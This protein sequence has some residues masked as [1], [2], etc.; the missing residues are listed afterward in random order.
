MAD[1]LVVPCPPLVADVVRLW[2]TLELATDAGTRAVVVLNR[3]RTRT[4]SLTEAREV[5]A[6]A[7][8]VPDLLPGMGQAC[9]QR[10]WGSP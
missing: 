6:D 7:G 8:V 1:L 9:C 5:L 2:P 4:R 3:V 10:R